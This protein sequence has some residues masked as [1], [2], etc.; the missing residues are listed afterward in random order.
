ME[1]E[2]SI[3]VGDKAFGGQVTIKDWHK[4]PTEEAKKAAVKLVMDNLYKQAI[5]EAIEEAVS[6]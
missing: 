3:R 4:A 5:N 6:D 1:F 2:L